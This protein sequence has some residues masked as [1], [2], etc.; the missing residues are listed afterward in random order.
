MKKIVSFLFLAAI[1]FSALLPETV[2]SQEKILP[3]R[4]IETPDEQRFYAPFL[5]FDIE[6]FQ[7]QTILEA[8]PSAEKNLVLKIED[9]DKYPSLAADL[10]LYIADL[11]NDGYRVSL[12]LVRGGGPE[13]YRNFF[14][15]H[16]AEGL[17]GVIGDPPAA[18][19]EMKDDFYGS[20]EFP[21]D[22]YYMD[23][24]GEWLDTDGNS[25]LD[26]HRGN[27]NPEIWLSRT[28]V[29]SLSPLG[30]EVSLLK[31]YFKRNH[32]W[33]QNWLAYKD[34]QRRAMTYVE[35]DWQSF[36][37]AIKR[38]LEQIYPDVDLFS[39][40]MATTATDYVQRIQEDYEFVTVWAHGNVGTQVFG[41]EPW[42]YLYTADLLNIQ[43]KGYFY[44]LFS[45]GNANFTGKITKDSDFI[46]PYIGGA[47]L[48]FGNGLAVVGSTK[49]GGMVYSEA[50]YSA[51]AEGKSF[52]EAFLAWWK[53]S[54]FTPDSLL[55]R[56]WNYG[57]TILG[58]PTLRLRDKPVIPKD[59]FNPG[60]IITG[61][62]GKKLSIKVMVKD[63]KTG[64][65]VS[66]AEVRFSGLVDPEQ[67]FTTTTKG[68]V[69]LKLS[70]KAGQ[71]TT[72]KLIISISKEGYADWE[73][74][75]EIN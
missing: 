27:T 74:T 42:S 6:P 68:K 58:D 40:P 62:P 53:N 3:P 50:F 57:M 23:L 43:P 13:D 38:D 14:K 29:G 61:T 55:F 52:G 37:P 44:N 8:E 12:Y 75:Y 51:L 35:N 45:C 5:S 48:F 56:Q 67:V 33:R 28:T 26:T 54:G 32:E 2:F 34:S 18:W 24:D 73:K 21:T 30:D 65:V 71:Q 7:F 1:G 60:V 59:E 36:G 15:S 72:S 11:Q 9:T 4:Y 19:F 20:T 46:I 22:L 41:P 69:A 25:I 64:K 47:Y 39:D 31:D 10:V 17:V 70:A 66:G 49:T 63:S 16:L